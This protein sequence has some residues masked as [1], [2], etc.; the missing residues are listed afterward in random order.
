[1]EENNKQIDL[2]NFESFDQHSQVD[3][4]REEIKK[5]DHAY[6]VND[7][8]IIDDFSYNFLFAKLARLESDHPEWHDD[9]SPTQRVGGKAAAQFKKV[10]HAAPMLSIK[11][12]T[13]L[14]T[15]PVKKFHARVCAKLGLKPDDPTLEYLCEYKYDGL[16]LTLR[17]EKRK[18]VQA[19]TRGN[20]VEGEDVTA[21]ARMIRDIPLELPG[22]LP[23]IF[24]VRGEVYMRHADFKRLNEEILDR[25]ERNGTNERLFANPRNAAAGSL[26][27]LD[28]V[29][30][31]QRRLSFMPYGVGE[32]SDDFLKKELVTTQ[33]QLLYLLFNCGFKWTGVISLEFTSADKVIDRF[34]QI[35]DAR[36]NLGFDIDGVV[37]KVNDLEYQRKLGFN[38]REPNWAIALKFEAEERV[39][40]VNDIKVQVGRTGKLTPVAIVE[41]VLVGGVMVTKC[42]LHN[43][44]E[45]RRKDV[46]VGDKVFIHRAGDVIPEIVCVVK[47]ERPDDTVAFIMP[48]SCPVCGSAVIKEDDQA[49]HYCTGGLVCDAQK[50]RSLLHFVQRRAMN[51]MGVGPELASKL[52]KSVIYRSIVD[53]YNFKKDTFMHYLQL[54]EK[55]GAKLYNAIERSKKTTL[56]RFIFA[57]GIRYVGEVTAKE[58][59]LHFKTLDALM[60]ASVMELLEVNSVG[61][62]IAISV[63]EFFHHEASAELV[64]DLLKT[65]IVFDSQVKFQLPVEKQHILDG[66]TFAITGTFP[67]LSR[68]EVQEMIEAAGGKVVST[69]SRHTSYLIAGEG[70]GVKTIIA[71]ELGVPVIGESTFKLLFQTES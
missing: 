43:E 30:T 54:G 12:E 49:A 5:F 35:N 31:A 34:Y 19:A 8:P 13:D 69:V 62:A 58:L 9:A 42:T 37:V 55:T 28:P 56:A 20:G 61:D 6:Y 23:D 16:A 17:Y 21:N 39:T 18:L 25:N 7:S 4:L 24:E 52:V 60:S 47:E 53:L 50:E 38:G 44:S 68:I 57:L 41:P 63:H 70:G 71:T 14:E 59:A 10:A 11:T 45:A 67:T 32:I 15:M 1:M 26:R 36:K 27:Q 33:V 65:G 51:I 22:S 64:M 3:F 46:R 66:K 48:E 2:S 40:T 29:I